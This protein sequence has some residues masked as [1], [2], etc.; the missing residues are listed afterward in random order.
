MGL[1]SFKRVQTLD[2]EFVERY[3]DLKARVGALEDRLEAALD[4]LQRRYQRAEQA[5]RRLEAK[6]TNGPAPAPPVNVV[7][8]SRRLQRGPT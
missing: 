8:Y 5:E 6:Q 1:F 3:W 4:D 2:E 7:Q